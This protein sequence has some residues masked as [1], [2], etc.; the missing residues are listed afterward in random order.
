[1][2]RLPLRPTLS[3]PVV[4][5]EDPAHRLTSHHPA[6]VGARGQGH[7]DRH[8][9]GMTCGSSQNTPQA[10]DG[11][12]GTAVCPPPALVGAPGRDPLCQ[13]N[14]ENMISSL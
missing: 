5:T 9:L 2:F 14:I 6:L 10:R 11:H 4:M 3:S 8:L 13:R 12:P 7:K 1:M